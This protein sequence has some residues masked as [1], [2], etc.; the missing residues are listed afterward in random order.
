MVAIGNLVRAAT[1]GVVLATA[2]MST[3][4]SAQTKV[5]A[6]HPQEITVGITTF[7]SGP[8]SVFG[9][10]GRDAAVMMF[11]DIN[12]KGGI[13]GAKVKPVFIDEGG[14][15][16]QVLSEYRRV[17]EQL[18]APLMMASISSGN[19]LAIAPV[20]EDLKVINLMWDCLTQRVT[21]DFSY[22]Y[23]IRPHGYGGPEQL[24]V[25]LY[26][27]QSNPNFKTIAGVN[28][29]YSAGRDMWDLFITALRALRPDIKVV[30]EL[31]PKFGATD[32]STEIS[33]LQAL[34]P[35]VIFNSSWG[36]DLDTFMQ[37]ASLRGLTRQ[38]QFVLPLG[39]SSLERL[40]AAIPAGVIV[41]ARGDHYFLSPQY[42]DNQELA[43]FVK[44][45]RDRTKAYPIYPVFHMAQSIAA[46]KAAYEKAAAANGGNWP[47]KEQALAA[48]KGLKFRGL[49]SEITIREDN[50]GLEDQLVGTTV[51][52]SDYPFAV[53][54]DIKVYPGALVSTPVGQKTLD[55]LKSV[56]PTLNADPGVQTFKRK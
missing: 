9:V 29:D 30:A 44:K 1:C 34:R 51:R 54:D 47:T 48:F 36:G 21:E 46:M 38:S 5:A 53:L 50:Q 7:L 42:K 15:V 23:S 31:F 22:K 43:A 19:C 45:Y 13:L 11:E 3:P 4:A 52:T 40:G 24:A 2:A 39:E 27:V 25:A 41:G 26:L 12:E 10:P 8:A 17:V 33:R 35:D 28:Q 55:W 56:K 32:Y 6:G 18:K 16:N 14:S 49:T 37:Q 20:A